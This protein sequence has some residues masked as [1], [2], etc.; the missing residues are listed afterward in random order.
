MYKLKKNFFFPYI[1]LKSLVLHCKT[2]ESQKH[3]TTEYVKQ[4]N[5]QAGKSI[6]DYNL[7]GNFFLSEVLLWHNYRKN[8]HKLL[9]LNS[10]LLRASEDNES[11]QWGVAFK[12]NTFPRSCG[13]PQSANYSSNSKDLYT[14]AEL[15]MCLHPPLYHLIYL[16]YIVLRKWGGPKSV[17]YRSVFP[18]QVLYSD[19]V[20]ASVHMHA[21]D[22]LTVITWQEI[23]LEI[24]DKNNTAAIFSC[25]TV[26]SHKCCDIATFAGCKALTTTFEGFQISITEKT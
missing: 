5:S 4:S 24:R 3:K 10:W 1:Q 2:G 23:N 18:W 26:H 19:N 17:Q 22:H 25:S 9:S 12:V 14:V 13:A 21:S 8:H 7:H 6:D 20:F 11:V 15:N 16:L